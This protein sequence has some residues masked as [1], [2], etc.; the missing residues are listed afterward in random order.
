MDK[1]I[2]YMYTFPNGKR[3]IGITSNE[4]KRKSEHKH[5]HMNINCKKYNYLFYRAL[6]K[7][8]WDNVKYE[9]LYRCDD[10]NLI[11]QLEIFYIKKYKTFQKDGYGYNCTLGGDGTL[12]YIYT[13]AHREKIRKT[14]T[15]RIKSE[16]V[17]KLI[18]EKLSGK[19]N[20]RFIDDINAYLST[21]K[22]R[23]GFKHGL[24]NR[25]TYSFDDFEE[26]IAPYSLWQI[27]KNGTKERKYYYKLKEALYGT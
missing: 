10:Y 25:P 24:K 14:S 2:V 13:D 21:P 16:K 6:R 27:R 18:S 26:I 19:N 11:K 17:K 8:G 12:G 3:Y 9:V 1:N 15:G 23:T 7:Y 20:P 5:D 22:T 4:R